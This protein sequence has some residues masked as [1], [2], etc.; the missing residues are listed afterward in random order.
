[1]TAQVGLGPLVLCRAWTRIDLR[2]QGQDVPG[3]DVEAVVAAFGDRTEVREVSR[4][5]LGLV[6]VVAGRRLRDGLQP[7]PRGV[8]IG[9]VIRKAPVVV[10][11]VAEEQ[12]EVQ[13]ELKQQVAGRLVLAGGG[14][15]RALWTGDVARGG[16]H[17]GAH[18]AP[19]S[20]TVTALAQPP[21]DN[22]TQNEERAEE[23][24]PEDEFHSGGR[25]HFDSPYG[26]ARSRAN[27]GRGSPLS[28][29]F[30]PFGLAQAAA[31]S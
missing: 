6:F 18:R 21:S 16:D 1:M 2:V 11:V 10:L 26:V 4:C 30:G 25:V 27:G 13:V 8:V 9:V 24:E 12:Y 22:Q 3:S 7:S 23:P 20:G 5:T 31:S 19:G 29:R 14:S 28:A 17:D 15:V